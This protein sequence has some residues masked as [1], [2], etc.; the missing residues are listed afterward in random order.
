MKN[1]I[2]T[3]K[4]IAGVGILTAV[5]IVLY[6]LGSFI[7]FG[8]VNIN[9]ALIPIAFG[10]IMYGP[11]CG[12]FLGL[13]NGLAVLLTPSTQGFLSVNVFGTL[14]ICLLKCT[15]A[16]LASGFMYKAFQ[17]KNILAV[18]CATCIIPFINTGIF[19]LGCLIFF[20]GFLES[21]LTVWLLINFSIELVL[22][23]ALTPAVIRVVNIVKEKNKDHTNE[24][25][26]TVNEEN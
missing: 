24:E 20:E 14:F 25:G 5:E 16:G 17:K 13:V 9:L 18:C 6:V 21:V 26:E 22:T 15:A 1:K 3:T 10:A 7:N 8:M 12:M 2:F 19:L 4:F 23:V 11:L